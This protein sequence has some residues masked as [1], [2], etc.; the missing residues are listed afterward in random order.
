MRIVLDA[1]V[2]FPTVMREVTTG[3][4]ARGVF[5]PIWSERIL[6]EWVRAAARLGEGMDQVAAGEA[7][8]LK[9]AFPGAMVE[10]ADDMAGHLPDPGDDHVLA[11]AVSGKADAIM[12][13]NTRDFPLRVLSAHGIARSD[14]DGFFMTCDEALLREVVE[15][16]HRNAETRSGEAKALRLLLKRTGLPRLA[17]RLAR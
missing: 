16:V 8:L 10:D 6:N 2:L 14:P 5:T 1:C 12:T 15:D 4:A 11:T 3:V 17:K 7:A 9:A 13:V